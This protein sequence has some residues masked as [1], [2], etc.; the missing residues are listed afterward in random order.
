MG[1]GSFRGC[2][3]PCTLYIFYDLP[4]QIRQT[5]NPVHL[6]QNFNAIGY[7]NRLCGLP[8]IKK[9]QNFSL[10][11]TVQEN[12]IHKVS[13]LKFFQ[14]CSQLNM[15]FKMNLFCLS[16]NILIQDQISKKWATYNVPLFLKQTII[17]SW[18]Q[19]FII[20]LFLLHIPINLKCSKK[21]SSLHESNHRVNYDTVL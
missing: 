5:L 10:H 8:V 20:F 9:A 2:T 17:K 12:K 1:S 6:L 21:I 16:N 19:K 11:C 18:E 3:D 14:Y 13:S 15:I 4:L 7:K